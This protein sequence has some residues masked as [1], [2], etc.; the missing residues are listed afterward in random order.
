MNRPQVTI[1][2]DGSWRTKF[3]KGAWAALIVSGPYWQIIGDNNSQTTISRMEMTAV[4]MGLKS[5]TMPCN[6]TVISDSTLVVNTI[7]NWLNKWEY[8]NYKTS[9]GNDVANMDLVLEL[10]ELKKIHIINAMWIKSHTNKKDINSLGNNVVDTLAQ[11]L[12]M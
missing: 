12:S 2:T 6:V 7:N 1:Y 10:S 5:L 9:R 3:K 4:I 8:N 11:S